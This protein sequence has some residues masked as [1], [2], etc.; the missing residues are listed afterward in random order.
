MV[1][2][3]TA[4][5]ARADVCAPVSIGW[6][7]YPRI[8]SLAADDGNL[9]WLRDAATCGGGVEIVR[10]PKSG[11]ASQVLTSFAN[12]DEIAAAAGTVY[13]RVGAA[14]YAFSVG[15]P[16]NVRTVVADDGTATRGELAADAG[17]VYFAESIVG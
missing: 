8:A 3:A 14:I 17:G 12:V 9:Y 10:T 1:T 15:A 4:G 6:A 5:I 16:G 13:A 11:G 7:V 2:L